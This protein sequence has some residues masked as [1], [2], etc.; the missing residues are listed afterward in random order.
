MEKQYVV[1]YCTLCGSAVGV[2][3][4]GKGDAGD[5]VERIPRPFLCEKC[6]G[7]LMRS[8]ALAGYCDRCGRV[9]CIYTLG[10]AEELREDSTDIASRI[11]KLDA[12]RFCDERVNE[13]HVMALI[14]SKIRIT[15]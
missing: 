15:R 13:N 14:R 5:F 8:R 2:C 10:A 3:L 12:C 9:V 7:L 4:N 11:V 6:R 1:A